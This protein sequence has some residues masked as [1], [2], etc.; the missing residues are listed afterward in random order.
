[1]WLFVHDCSYSLQNHTSVTCTILRVFLITTPDMVPS[2]LQVDMSCLMAT[3]SLSGVSSQQNLYCVWWTYQTCLTSSLSYVIKFS[4]SQVPLLSYYWYPIMQQ[5]QE[6]YF[7]EGALHNCPCPHH[8]G[9]QLAVTPDGCILAA[10]GVFVALKSKW[11][12]MDSPNQFIPW[13]EEY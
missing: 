11:L 6:P 12:N 4:L 13:M 5:Y 8:I 10:H 9:C 3:Y 2:I 7:L 1:M